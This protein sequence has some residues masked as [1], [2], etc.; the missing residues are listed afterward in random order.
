MV[1]NYKQLE[2][3]NS[4]EMLTAIFQSALHHA[5]EDMTLYENQYKNLKCH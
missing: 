5:P 2:A 3:A 1:H 4:A